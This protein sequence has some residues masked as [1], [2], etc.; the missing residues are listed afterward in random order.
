MTV[1]GQQS[2]LE[3]L[4]NDARPQGTQRARSNNEPGLDMPMALAS[5]TRLALNVPALHQIGYRPD[6]D[7]KEE[8]GKE[9]E[10]NR[11]GKSNK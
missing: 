10:K 3:V 9:K 7:G 4:M 2:G 1:H 5:E 8:D 11:R 6:E